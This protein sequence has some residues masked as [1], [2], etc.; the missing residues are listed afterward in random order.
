M[1]VQDPMTQ[2]PLVEGLSEMGAQ[3]LDA[4]KGGGWAGPGFSPCHW[5]LEG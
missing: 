3:V 4:R 1:P 5:I 2:D